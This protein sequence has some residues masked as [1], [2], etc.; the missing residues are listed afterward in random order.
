M[1]GLATLAVLPSALSDF[2]PHFLRA[3]GLVVPIALVAGVGI[4][5]V[6]RTAAQHLS[7]RVAIGIAVA[8]LI[9]A[10]ATSARDFRLWL[11][12]PDGYLVM[13]RHF[14]QAAQVV[15]EELS[16]ET[17][18]Y[19]SPFSAWHPNPV[20]LAT[21]REGPVAAF[22]SHYCL[23][24]NQSGAAYVSLPR[25]E[26][27]FGQRLAK[28]AEV[29]TLAVSERLI[30]GQAA[31]AVL[32]AAPLPQFDSD[33]V[34]GVFD[35]SIKMRLLESIPVTA[36]AGD[37]VRVVLAIQGLRELGRPYNIFIHLYD[38]VVPEVGA[39]IISQGDAEICHSYPPPYWQ[40][41]EV[42]VQ[43]FVLPLPAEMSS[44]RYVIAAGV[45]ETPVGPRLPIAVP[46]PHT[47]DYLI[48]QE[49]EVP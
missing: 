37:T 25:Y 11:E 5:S 46:Q 8:M 26:A 10:G 36:A 22:D 18:L 3:I 39:S 13:E 33:L 9:L 1:L 48:L 30:D 29:E 49:I 24:L 38:A 19:V 4:E 20:V 6:I 40:L 34:Y 21:G 23:V 15:D 35:E 16:P 47:Q 44:G 12:R 42:I 27:G 2:A 41:G 43:E 28:W 17:A 7:V 31:Y 45:Y 32:Q 14:L